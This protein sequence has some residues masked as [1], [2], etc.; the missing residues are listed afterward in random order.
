MTGYEDTLNA[1]KNLLM[2]PL[3]F[4]DLGIV[5]VDALSAKHD[6][7]WSVELHRHPWFEFNYVS[8][9]S[10]YTTIEGI[11]FLIQEGQSYLIP[12]G[13]AHA[14]RNAEGIGDDG[15]CLRW[16][17]N[18]LSNR[19]EGLKSPASS[20]SASGASNSTS[21]SSSISLSMGQAVIDIF[22][23]ARPYALSKELTAPLMNIRSDQ[24]SFSIQSAFVGWLAVLFEEWSWEAP[25]LLHHS[26]QADKNDSMV[27]QALLYLEEYYASSFKVQDLATALHVSYRHLSRLFKHKTG[28]SIIEKLTDI[29]VSHAKKL[30]KDS[31]MTLREIAHETGFVNEFYFSNQFHR[32]TFTSPKEFRKLSKAS[33]LGHT[34]P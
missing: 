33:S 6:P 25:D 14:H 3:S 23:E 2:Q 27:Q 29:R 10:V 24:S 9:G 11:E 20:H 15:F 34:F 21:S 22:Q 18:L 17:F 7:D 1:C 30:L 32:Y 13:A 16:Q 5:L 31:N 19:N 26:H 28:I 4:N 12:P 8:T